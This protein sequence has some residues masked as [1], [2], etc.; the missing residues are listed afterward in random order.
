METRT[1]LGRDRFTSIF[2]AASSIAIAIAAL[3]GTQPVQAQQEAAGGNEAVYM[4]RG[5]DRDQ[6]LVDKARKEGTLTFYT[7]MAP[8]ESR[9]LAAAFEKKY[10]IKVQ[11]WRGPNEELVQRI[12]TEGKS[13]RNAFDV[14]ET[15]GTEA[16]VIGREG[17][18]LPFYSPYQGDFPAGAIPASRMWM[19]DRFNYLV[20]AFNTNKVKRE[21]LPKS[22]EGFADPKWKGQIAIE[23]GDWDWMVAV[24][25]KL[26][27]EKGEAAFRNLAAQRPEL[28]KGHPLL[29]QLVAAGEVPVSLTTFLSN[30]LSLKKRGGPIDYVAI[31]PVLAVPFAIAVA[32]HAPHPHAA[33]LFAEYVLSPEGQELLDSLGRL[34]AS[35]KIKNQVGFR[36]TT[37]DVNASLSESDKREKA[38]NALFLKH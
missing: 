30:V 7:S 9:P 10:G 11:L 2:K 15:N 24:Q 35:N 34:P 4:Y 13:K 29:A 14:L 38:W 28:R 12:L 1:G 3:A 22:Y 17:F 26:G 25:Q 8:P 33:L 32:R 31:E 16:E 37:L 5:A 21:D 19:P 6:S 36:F 18:L 20:T 27:K 23:S